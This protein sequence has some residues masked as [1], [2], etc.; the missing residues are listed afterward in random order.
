MSKANKN[1]P[2]S[3]AMR[4]PV[5]QFPEA[6]NAE[7]EASHKMLND[8][9]K[10]QTDKSKEVAAPKEVAVNLESMAENIKGLVQSMARIEKLL[11]RQVPAEMLTQLIDGSQKKNTVEKELLA[12]I[13]PRNRETATEVMNVLQRAFK[14][15]GS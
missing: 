9:Q 2:E 8:V 12:I 14:D 15:Y 13:D 11:E 1:N 5:E 7:V 4:G 3:S 10:S 6:R